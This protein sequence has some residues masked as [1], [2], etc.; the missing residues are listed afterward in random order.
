MGGQILS[1]EEAVRRTRSVLLSGGQTYC[2]VSQVLIRKGIPGERLVSFINGQT[3]TSHMIQGGDMVIRG[4]GGG[5][6]LHHLPHLRF[7]QLCDQE[8]LMDW[9]H[10]HKAELQAQGFAAYRARS[11][12]L[13]LQVDSA[14]I[15]TYL[16]GGVFLSAWD[17]PLPIQTGDYL[18]T[19]VPLGLLGRPKEVYEVI[20]APMQRFSQIYAPLLDNERPDAPLSEISLRNA[21][22]PMPNI[23]APPAQTSQLNS[24]VPTINDDGSGVLPLTSPASAAVRAHSRSTSPT[25]TL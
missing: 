13:A 17:T 24:V 11:R 18:C 3:R 14:F 8:P 5:E 1:Q 6:E 23:G 15:D 22:P 2:S 7:Q 12:C 9:E 4:E 21:L 25:M 16:T 19:P 10:P 20:A